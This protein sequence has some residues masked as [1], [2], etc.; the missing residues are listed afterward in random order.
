M[1]SLLFRVT[2]RLILP[3]ALIFAAFMS[4]KGHNAPGGGFIGGLTASVALMLFAMANGRQAL[5][6][7]IPL[8]PRLLI[9]VGLGMAWTTSV[10]PLLWGRPLLTS[11]VTELHL[12]FGQSI[13]FVSAFFFD[14]GVMLVVI[15]VSTG[16]IQRLGEE[17][18]K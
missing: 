14:F 7:L 10:L 5:I 9:F 17:Q 11:V 8:H 2:I 4:F 13:H 1:S 12:G 6:D 16:M 15:G 3:L 18:T